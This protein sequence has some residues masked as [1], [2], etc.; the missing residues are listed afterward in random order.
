[1][2]N[3]LESEFFHESSIKDFEVECVLD[4]Q[5]KNGQIEYLIKWKNYD[6][7]HNCWKTP[8]EMNCSSL[9]M[10]FEQKRKK[11]VKISTKSRHSK[12]TRVNSGHSD[13]VPVFY[14][15]ADESESLSETSLLNTS[16]M[17]SQPSTSV[18]QHTNAISGGFFFDHV[19]IISIILGATK[20]YIQTF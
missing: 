15:S 17:L 8:D 5:H 10:A 13:D 2:A 14:R 4:R 20:I 18:T 6:D 16:T 1:M 12:R 7:S 19:H 11:R 9:I 3:E